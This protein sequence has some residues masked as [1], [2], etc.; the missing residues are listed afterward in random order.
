MIEEKK[1]IEKKE[2]KNE[3]EEII[4]PQNLN[5]E[6]EEEL[7]LA[8][9]VISQESQNLSQNSLSP[10]NGK[11]SK[12]DKIALRLN[13]I[14]IEEAKEMGVDDPQEGDVIQEEVVIKDFGRVA[15]QTAK[16]VVMQ[17]LREAEREIVFTDFQGKVGELATG[18]IQKVSKNVIIV[19]LGRVE[20]IMPRSEQVPSEKYQMNQ[21]IKVLITQVN[22][23]PKG[24]QVIVSRSSN[25]F[26]KR[27]FEQQIPEVYDGIVEIK[28][29][30]REAGSK[31]KVAVMSHD[32]DVEPL[33]ACVGRAGQRINS[34]MDELVNE[35]IDIV[36]WNSDVKE[37]IKAALSPAS[38]VDI[39][40]DE[41]EKAAEVIVPETELS[42]AIGKSGQNVRMAARLVGCKIDIKGDGNAHKDDEEIEETEEV[43][44]S[45]DK[46]LVTKEVK[47]VTYSEKM[48]F[49]RSALEEVYCKSEDDECCGCFYICDA[50]DEYVI[51][52]DYCEDK[53]FKIN[54]EI[55][56]IEAT[57]TEDEKT[58]IKFNLSDTQKKLVDMINS[59]M[60]EYEQ[61]K[62][63]E[64]NEAKN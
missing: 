61:A 24:P 38:V 20:A 48:E 44:E 3:K 17:K 8:N 26:I 13:E 28:G 16:Q 23:T 6:K 53:Y 39:T 7:S 2:E 32:E 46:I 30:I 51:I 35:K 36:I 47:N 18:I 12:A 42:L 10:K 55:N 59:K 52:R 58:E 5:G 33:G 21:R 1:N 41:E 34:I 54:Y 31:T 14:S 15:A 27:L 62:Q 50:T 43:K 4:I 56:T 37:Y 57:E 29:I 25:D 9:S 19:N 60:K 64:V 11:L 45:E 49:L 63:K 40:L 22:Q